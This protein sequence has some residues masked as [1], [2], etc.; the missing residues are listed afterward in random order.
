MNIE[1]FTISGIEIAFC[2]I[3]ESEADLAALCKGKGID[4][5]NITLIK[6]ESYRVQ[7]MAV[8]L[9]IH[10][11]LHRKFSLKHR[12][13]GA[14][15]IEGVNGLSISH[16]ERFVMVAISD[17]YDKIG[18]DI[19]MLSDR[20][21]RVR[22]KFLSENELRMIPSD[23]IL[24]N[25]QAWTAKEALF[26]ALGCENVIFAR[27]LHLIFDGHCVPIEAEETRTKL[28]SRFKL[29]NS[30]TDCYTYTIAIIK[31]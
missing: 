20:V 6:N 31:T 2:E 3:S 16:T 30:S 13:N 9:C 7:K 25:A 24:P 11:L 27:H 26:K 22:N 28:K 23:S 29:I 18:I 12:I 19:E 21:L 14:P 15:E 17:N 10:E 8:L 5:S 1:R 4:I